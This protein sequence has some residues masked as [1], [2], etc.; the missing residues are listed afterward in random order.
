MLIE[1]LK[2]PHS[3]IGQ[4]LEV[5][6]VS[7]QRLLYE[8]FNFLGPIQVEVC[9]GPEITSFKSLA[10]SSRIAE[11]SALRLATTVSSAETITRIPS[12][13]TRSDD[14]YETKIPVTC[15]F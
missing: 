14:T 6:H 10:A 4:N 13:S 5:I 7:F 1:L 9:S 12:A 3:S 2:S 11:V 15:C 8:P